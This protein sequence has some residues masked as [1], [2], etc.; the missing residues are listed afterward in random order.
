M[1]IWCLKVS[2]DGRASFGVGGKTPRER[3]EMYNFHG[4]G[5]IEKW[6]LKDISFDSGSKRDNSKPLKNVSFFWRGTGTFICDEYTKEKI[7]SRFND[8]QFL[9]VKPIEKEIAEKTNYYL[10]NILRNIDGLN[11]EKCEFEKTLGIIISKIK[12]YSFKKESLQYPIF[13]VVIENKIFNEI[14]VT[15]EFKNYVEEVNI[16]GFE[17]IEVFDFENEEK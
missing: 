3:L 7:S 6:I 12:K 13:N 2:Y 10:V 14:Y 4:K 17:F 11:V 8:I 15:D 1:K 9:P 5:Y 16:E